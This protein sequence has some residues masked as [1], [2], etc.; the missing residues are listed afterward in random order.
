[1]TTIKTHKDFKPVTINDKFYRNAQDIYDCIKNGIEKRTVSFEDNFCIDLEKIDLLY[2]IRGD[3]DNNNKIENN[4]NNNNKSYELIARMKEKNDEE[5]FFQL[6]SQYC[7]SCDQSN[8]VVFVTHNPM[9]FMNVILYQFDDNDANRF[10]IHRSLEQ[11]NFDVDFIPWCYTKYKYKQWV[12]RRP[13]TEFGAVEF[14]PNTISTHPNYIL[15]ER[16]V[17]CCSKSAKDE[18]FGMNREKIPPSGQN[19][20]EQLQQQQW[21]EEN[22]VFPE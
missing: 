16:F 14:G 11:D 9:L 17:P 15:F 18:F 5:I 2:Y 12:Y 8:G 10:F 19:L 4:N 3:N 22:V 1:M 6:L 21:E 20:F 7:H 13:P